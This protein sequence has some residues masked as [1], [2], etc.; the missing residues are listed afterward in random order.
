MKSIRMTI[1]D[2]GY[3]VMV[4]A[5]NYARLPLSLWARAALIETAR[6]LVHKE[7]CETPAAPPPTVYKWAGKPVSEE[8]YRTKKAMEIESKRAAGMLP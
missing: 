3:E 4:K 7:K 5:S 6:S 1:D 2:A 8:E